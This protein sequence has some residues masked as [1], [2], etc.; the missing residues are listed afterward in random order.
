MSLCVWLL[1]TMATAM[2]DLTLAYDRSMNDRVQSA[3]VCC[4]RGGGG[5]SGWVDGEGC[6][7]GLGCGRRINVCVGC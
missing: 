4:C 5:G 6:A 3:D 1:C 2:L 7:A